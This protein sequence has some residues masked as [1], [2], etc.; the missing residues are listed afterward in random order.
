MSADTERLSSA[1]EVLVGDEPGRGGNAVYAVYVAVI[2]AGAYGVPAAQAFFRAVDPAWIE[3]RLGG[4]GAIAV[5]ALALVAFLAFAYRAGRIRGP[6]VPDLPYLDTVAASPID[7]NVVLRSWWRL[8][9]LGC[10]VVGLLAGLVVGAGLAISAVASPL[11]LLPSTVCGMLGG[12][13]IA[14]AWLHGQVRS[15]PTGDR[16]LSVFLRQRRSLRA[17]HITALRTQSARSVTI[18]GAVLA[19]DLRAARLD[20]G[21]AST[22]GRRFRLKARGPIPTMVSRD[23]LGLRRAPGAALTGLVLTGA[24]AYLLVFASA[25]GTPSV[26]ALAGMLLAYLGV[27]TW[28]EGLRL[29]GDNAGTPPLIGLAP[30]LEARAHLI[31]PGLGYL[32]CV[33]VT[34][35]LALALGHASAFGLVWAVL[36]GGLLLATQVMAAFRGLPPSAIYSPQAGVPAMILWYGI[37]VIV[38]LVCGTASTAF[39]TAA[40]GGAGAAALVITTTLAIVYARSRVTSLFDGHRQ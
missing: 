33:A 38:A 15:W 10:L 32:L 16:G 21:P 5:G 28:S 40:K 37:P 17:L 29:Q 19:G 35:A 3:A 39:I 14:G 36:L 26:V 27:S 13:L 30:E 34:G 9:L 24:G 4:P 8:G 2:A 20:V 22:R 6:V 1:R 11:V 12:L 25:P 18:G 31:L 23:W 7:R